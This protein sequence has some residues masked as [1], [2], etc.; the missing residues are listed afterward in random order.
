[1]TLKELLRRV[2]NFVALSHPEKITLFAWWLH[3]HGGRE[4]FDV[5]AIRACYSSIDMQ[6]SANPAQD[7]SRLEAK[8][9][10]TLLKDARGY[11][12]EGSI[13]DAL[14]G[15][16]GE[17]ESTVQ[18]TQLLKD[19]PGKVSDEAERLFLSEAMTC[20]RNRAFR[21]AI[22]MTWNLTY[23]HLLNWLMA[24]P[25]RV[26]AFNGCIVARIGQKRGAGMSMTKREDFEELKE[27]EVLDICSN[28]GVL[29]SSNMKKILDAQLTKRNMAAHPSL[30]EIRE[31]EANETIHTLVRNVV[32]K[33]T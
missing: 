15:K 7:I 8:R 22:V 33:L 21:A 23:D 5:S 3:T 19:L 18:V 4:R 13:R 31:P 32:L 1:M 28:A 11:R 25:Q 9:P 20:Y 29:P 12:V 24:D 26:A 14:D 16:Y 30:L 17:H 2:P 6:S 27:S 10:R